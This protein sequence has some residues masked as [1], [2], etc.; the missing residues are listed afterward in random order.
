MEKLGHA[1]KTRNTTTLQRILRE[2]RT[3]SKLGPHEPTC[4]AV[5]PP[6]S[7]AAVSCLSVASTSKTVDATVAVLT[8]HTEV[9]DALGITAISN[10]A[11]PQE[12]TPDTPT[13]ESISAQRY[14]GKCIFYDCLE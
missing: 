4:S 14:G 2:S 8:D 9:A 3:W 10:S 12:A 13:E 5:D 1:D 11:L 7:C 6:V